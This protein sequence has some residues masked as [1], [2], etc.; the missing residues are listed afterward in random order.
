MINKITKLRNL[1][2]KHKI[3]GYLIS[4][5]D[6]Y[7]LEYPPEANKRLEYI[8][9]FTG[10]NG[11]ALILEDTILFFTDGRYI[12]QCQKELDDNLFQIFDQKDLMNFPWGDYIKNNEIIAYDAK[13]FTENILSIFNKLTLQQ[14]NE[15]LIDKIWHDRPASPSSTIYNY[16]IKFAG[17]SA[18]EKLD[19]CRE[20][21]QAYCAEYL[22]ITDT[23]SVCWLFNLRAS[24]L[25]FAPIL[26]A[27]CC[28][29]R[30]KVYLFTD[31]ARIDKKILS[32]KPFIEVMP[33]DSLSDIIKTSCGKIL[34]DNNAITK[35]YFDLIKTKP[36]QQIQNPCLLWKACKNDAEIQGM[37]KG[38]IED[39][40]AVC[41]FLAFLAGNELSDYSEYDLGVELTNFRAKGK[42]YISNSFPSIVGF[43]ANG[44]VIHYRAAQNTA[45]KI[46]GSGLLLID[47]G[48]QYLGA[49]TDITR[50]VPIGQQ[51]EIYKK[52]YTEILKGHLNL[53]M[54][55]FPKNMVT[56]ANLDVLA[57][58]FLWQNGN[59]Y[60]HGTG[61]GVG[62]FLSVHEGP[63]N[64]SLNS[65]QTKFT[66]GMVVS[67]EPG[68]YI[69]GEFGIRIENM[70]YV[71][72]AHEDNFLEFEMLTLVPY[73]K[74]L[75]NFDM[76]N[77][78][79]FSYLVNYYAKIKANIMP[80]L[81]NNAQKWLL[82]QIEF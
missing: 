31:I 80:N 62:S 37:I 42:N 32:E 27:N 22:I 10:S 12:T 54:V 81:S 26:L 50:V 45:K 1:C 68:F 73:E 67:N 47:S 11:L 4:T 7:L 72:N 2:K 53:A 70:M 41:E 34:F 5:K 24:D 18:A 55:K 56:G 66:K 16:D 76:L 44:A 46:K 39:G 58:Q 65:Y 49:T 59:D 8:T 57:R 15:N 75:I 21:L 79:E 61:H 13:I 35:Y 19:K 64:I 28:V 30:D 6:E 9:G 48:G 20:F 36:H 60:A 78:K 17:K 51:K 25:E 3:N 69:T 38:H 74:K 52:Y 29:T 14:L 77:A 63:Q 82:E 43:Q 71:K 23:E 40:V 33:E